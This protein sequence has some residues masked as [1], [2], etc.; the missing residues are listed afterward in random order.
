MGGGGVSFLEGCRTQ[1]SR[2]LL[3]QEGNHVRVGK[4]RMGLSLGQQW[5]VLTQ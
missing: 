3:Q 1:L 4:G 2:H 5:R